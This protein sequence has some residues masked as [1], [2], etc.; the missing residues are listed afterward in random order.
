MNSYLWMLERINSSFQGEQ[1]RSVFC[2]RC[3]WICY[4]V[5]IQTLTLFLRARYLEFI[6]SLQFHNSI[7]AY[8]LITASEIWPEFIITFTPQL[9]AE[10][11]NRCLSW[12]LQFPHLWPTILFR[13]CCEYNTLLLQEAGAYHAPILSCLAVY[14]KQLQSAIF[15]VIRA[16]Y[17]LAHIYLGCRNG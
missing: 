11:L 1:K 16:L 5:S 3:P 7:S 8:L 2:I 9:P 12:L 6:P 14:I 13:D 4:H 10:V 15:L 17:G